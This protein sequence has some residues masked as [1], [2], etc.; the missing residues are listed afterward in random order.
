MGNRDQESTASVIKESVTMDTR[1]FLSALN[2]SAQSQIAFFEDAVRRLGEQH[3]REWAL[4]AL[5]STKLV[6][7]DKDANEFMIADYAK[8]KGGRIKIS[9]VRR[10]ELHEDKKPELFENTCLDLI[11]AI[12]EGDNKALDAA[13]NR[14][15]ASRFRSTAIPSTGLVRTKDGVIRHIVV[16]DAKP[17]LAQRLIEHICDH[18]VLTE[19]GKIEGSFAREDF[20]KVNFGVGE[21]TTR[22]LVAKQMCEVAQNAWKSQNFQTLVE[23]VA[24]LIC[25]EKLEEAIDYSGKFLREN[26]EFCLLNPAQWR[27]LVSQALAT[28]AVFNEDLIGDVSVLMHKTNLKVNH[29]ELVDAWRKTAVRTGHPIML[30]NVDVLANAENFEAAYGQF[31]GTLME[32]AGETT[33]GALETGLLA[34]KQLV[35]KGDID[36]PTSEEL[37]E[38]INNLKTKGDSDSIWKA[39]EVLDGVRRHVTQAEGLSDF[40]EMP[41]PG[42]ESDLGIDDTQEDTQPEAGAETAQVTGG[43]DKPLR[44]T[45]EMDPAAMAASAN[46]AAAPSAP[47]APAGEDEFDLSSLNDIDLE[48]GEETEKEPENQG[49]EENAEDILAGLESKEA[50]PAITEDEI[51]DFLKGEFPDNP[52]AIE[53]GGVTTTESTEPATEAS[54]DVNEE[55]EADDESETVEESDD[56]YKLPDLQVEGIGIDADYGVIVE[57]SDLSPADVQGFND[58]L[59]DDQNEDDPN[60]LLAQ[61]EAYIRTNDRFKSKLESVKDPKTQQAMVTDLAG[62]L[63]AQRQAKDSM[64]EGVD[65]PTGVV[66]GK[67]EACPK[68]KKPCNLCKCKK[69]AVK[70]DQYKSPQTQLSKRGLKKAAINKLVKEGKLEWLNRTNEAVLGKFKGVEFVIDH[71]E[72]PVA[73]LSSNGNMQV[74]IP[75]SLVAGALYISEAS[76]KEADVDGFVKWLDENIESLRPCDDSLEEAVA[77]VTANDDGSVD[78][79]VSTG[80]TAAAVA[81]GMD[82]EPTVPPMDD[83][84]P[85]FMG[86]EGEEVGSVDSIGPEGVEPEADQEVDSEAETGETDKDNEDEVETEDQEVEVSEGKLP[87]HLKKFQFKKG[88]GKAKAK[89]SGKPESNKAEPGEPEAKKPE[90]ADEAD[91]GKSETEAK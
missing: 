48:G 51:K 56:P 21:L 61:A 62:K 89:K 10:V 49:T 85:E 57:D 75:E 90:N 78:V 3:G 29:D 83:V 53:Q 20:S 16:E 58:S 34:L 42:A 23:S 8:E 6:M 72:M 19:S 4:T 17:N 63:I 76:D 77:R 64:P 43:G 24:G 1:K 39:M 70:E 41:G 84:T 38:L 36:Q 15:A 81:A 67:D 18:F 11:D 52:D 44:V 79:E 25:K 59:K 65:A 35:S 46:A 5:H 60:A 28:R 9:N 2:N 80:D 91:D 50:Q 30:E 32:A 37:D 26:Q 88:A 45:V 47:A 87:E 74:P 14:I 12:E 31:L 33:K 69:E 13:Y 66:E 73:V 68:C 71:S 55:A 82:S 27:E 7:E 40:D 86:A 22:K 54:E